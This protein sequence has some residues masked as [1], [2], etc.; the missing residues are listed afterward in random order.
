MVFAAALIIR[1]LCLAAWTSQHHR[2]AW[3]GAELGFVALNL[4]EGRG[5]SSPLSEGSEPT[6]FFCPFAPALWV[7]VM[8]LC[9]GPSGWSAEVITFLQAFPGAF[10]SAMYWLIARRVGLRMSRFP[11]HM[12]TVVAAVSCVWPESLLRL[13]AAQGWYYVWQEAGVAALVLCAMRWWEYPRLGRGLALGA[14][15]GAV[16]LINPTPVPV[17]AVALVTPLLTRRHPGI[18]VARATALSGIVAALFVAP[19]I[20]RNAVVFGRFVP[21]RSNFGIELRQGNNPAGSV[22]QGAT[23]L[24]PYINRTERIRFGELGEGEY[25]RRAFNDAVR[26]MREHPG[27][28][29]GRIGKRMYVMWCTDVF[30]W[31]SWFDRPGAKWWNRGNFVGCLQVTTSASALIPL[32]VV[33]FGLSTGRLRGLPCKLLFLSLFLFLPL[34]YYFTSAN[35]FYSAAMRPWLTLLALMVLLRKSS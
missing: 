19:W 21:M 10:A 20:V 24:N 4:Y 5:F 34:P 1:L 15:A 16:G 18:A 28:T 23:S 12:P 32:A 17:F 14:V 6:A 9:G 29:A 27:T 31:W 33:L 13:I 11:A 2:V 3:G 26:Y 25:T 30:D 8:Y 35:D 22:R 7:A